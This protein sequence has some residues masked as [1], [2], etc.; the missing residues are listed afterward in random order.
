VE[1][2][3]IRRFVG[4]TLLGWSLLYMLK[5]MGEPARTGRIGLMMRYWL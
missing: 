1:K 3:T 4:D 5:T 2:I